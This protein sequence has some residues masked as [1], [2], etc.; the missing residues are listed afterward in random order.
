MCK[1]KQFSIFVI[2]VA[3]VI[4]GCLARPLSKPDAKT[5]SQEDSH[6][7]GDWTGESVCTAKEPSC[8]DEK[9][10][11][12][13]SKGS[14]PTI[15]NVNADRIVDGK[16]VNMGTLEFKYDKAAGK[17]VNSEHGSWDLKFKERK[18]EGTLTLANGTLFRRVTLRP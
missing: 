15:V 4:T 9:V 3:V 18:I 13:I 1:R 5:S 14:D 12:H 17:L 10:I 2:L 6:L 11:Y 8:R 16:A 7:F